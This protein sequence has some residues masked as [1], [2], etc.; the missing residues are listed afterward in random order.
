MQPTIQGT[1]VIY[2]GVNYRLGPFGFP[3]GTEAE[4]NGAL[5]LAPK[6]ELT[7]LRW[8]QK[9]IGTFGGDSKKASIST[10]CVFVG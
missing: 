6:D 5:N 2:V 7:A 8:V 3:Q 9:N 4:Q 10:S 1:P